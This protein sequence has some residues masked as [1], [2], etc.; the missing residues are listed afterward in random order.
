MTY[1]GE[2]SRRAGS[3]GSQGSGDNRDHRDHPRSPSRPARESRDARH[4]HQ[5]QPHRQYPPHRRS[6]SR[7]TGAA[8]QAWVRVEDVIKSTKAA[9]TAL[10]RRAGP[11]RPATLY[12]E[13]SAQTEVADLR[14][15]NPNAQL[16]FQAALQTELRETQEALA[17]ARMRAKQTQRERDRLAEDLEAATRANV[18]ASATRSSVALEGGDPGEGE[19]GTISAEEMDETVNSLLEMITAERDKATALEHHLDRA[20]G[21]LETERDAHHAMKSALAAHKDAVAEEFTAQEQNFERRRRS[22]ENFD[23]RSYR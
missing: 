7:P 17:E 3:V 23:T 22:S 20:M 2:A 12:S 10:K 5:Q 1:Y 14:D 4:A 9:E 8:P 18:V 21:E 11:T 6:S 19:P 13:A 16:K 15:D